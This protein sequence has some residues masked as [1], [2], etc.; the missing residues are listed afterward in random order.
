MTRSTF[1]MKTQEPI[2]NFEKSQELQARMHEIVPGGCHTYAKGDDQYPLLAPGFINH[3]KGCYVWDADGN[4][5]VEYGMGC[6]AVGLGHAYESVV[7]AARQE[8]EF[9]SNFTRPAPIELHCA[10]EFL[11]LVP[12]ADMVKFSKEGSTATSGAVKLARA[13]TGRAKVALCSDHP[14]FAIHDWFIGTTDIDAGIPQEIK[15]LSVTFRYND[16]ESL[17]RLF[18]LHPEQIACVILEPSKY[19]EPEDHFLHRVK[20]ICEKYGALFILDEMI[21]GFRLYAGG[22]QD[23]YDITPDLSTFGKAMANGFAVSALAGKRE[24]MEMGGL[25]HDKDRVFL[26][27]TTH[28]AET[29]ALAAAIATMNVYRTFTVVEQMAAQGEKLASGINEV[30]RRHELTDHVKIFG[31]PSNLVFATLDPEGKPSQGYRTL[32][33]QELIKN[34]V[35]GPS[36]VISYSHDREAIQHTVSAFD[37]ALNVY[38][39]ALEEGY[40]KYLVGRPTQTVYRRRNEPAYAK[41]LAPHQEEST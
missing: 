14:F 10:E 33:M 39:K 40:E 19:D 37:V 36:L 41:P 3:G 4:K 32:L 5:Y 12:R 17:E 20:E 29:H 6:R 30:I 9:G 24:Y 35:L 38:K 34:G 18:Q 28:G 15:D 16:P 13:V 22:A 8:L 11:S 2:V 21:T 1:P 26:L 31:H 7:E 23:L 27:S 25:Y